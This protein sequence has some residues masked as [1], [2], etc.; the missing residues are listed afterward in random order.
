VGV[1]G[2]A[3]PDQ[4]ANAGN[5]V[6]GHYVIGISFG[7]QTSAKTALVAQSVGGLL[8]ATGCPLR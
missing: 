2:I 8:I 3:F 4:C 6:V 7:V 1:N 5:K